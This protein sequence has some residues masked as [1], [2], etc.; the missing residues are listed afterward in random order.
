MSGQGIIHHGLCTKTLA[1][2]LP[3]IIWTSLRPVTYYHKA[4][5]ARG[6]SVVLDRPRTLEFKSRLWFGGYTDRQ[7]Q[8]HVPFYDPKVMKGP[9]PIRQPIIW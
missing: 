5:V 8:I 9:P 2:E 6:D 1:G 7:T 4:F 3:F